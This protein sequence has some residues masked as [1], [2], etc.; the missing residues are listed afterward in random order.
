MEPEA[1]AL[2]GIDFLALPTTD[3]AVP[4]R[5]LSLVVQQV[6]DRLRQGEHVVAHCRYGIGRASLVAAPVLVHEGV[7]SGDAWQR[8]STA[9]GRPADAPCPTPT[10][11]AHT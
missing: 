7:D 9:R 3:R 6:T 5:A 11:T 2:A 8:L 1:A 10:S 4:D